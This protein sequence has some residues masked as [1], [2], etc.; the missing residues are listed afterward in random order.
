MTEGFHHS[1]RPSPTPPS[2]LKGL[3]PGG[4]FLHP[5]RGISAPA[6]DKMLCL[7][8]GC[9]DHLAIGDQPI[10][11]ETI[12]RD[13]DDTHYESAGSEGERIKN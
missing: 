7:M 8:D 1:A 10:P 9:L 13:V 11:G 2:A 12:R 4:C 3:D 6:T 5:D